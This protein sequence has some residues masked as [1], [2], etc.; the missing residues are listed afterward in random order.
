MSNINTKFLEG[1][2]GIDPLK[3]PEGLWD[4]HT[5]EI[6]ENP[7]GVIP[8]TYHASYTP[9]ICDIPDPK[10]VISMSGQSSRFAAAGY[11]EPKFMIEVDGKKIIE[12]IVDLYPSD[13]DFLFI[14]NDDHAQDIDLVEFLEDLPIDQVSIVSVPVHKK[15]PV[16]CIDYIQDYIEDDTPVIFNYCDFS[17]D[18]DYQL[19]SDNN[20]LR[21][22]DAELNRCEGADGVIL[23]YTGFHPHMLINTKYAYCKVDKTFGSKILEVKEKESFTKYPMAEYASAGTYYFKKGSYVKKYFKELIEK[24]IN[25]DGE[26]YVSLVYNL[27]IRDGLMCRVWEC[28]RF[29][30]WGTPLDLDIYRRWSDYYRRVIHGQKEVTI[31]NC[32]TAMPMAGEGMRFREAGYGPPKPF[33]CINDQYMVDL[34][35]KCLPKTD[36]TILAPLSKYKTLF[37]VTDEVDTGST[38]WIDEVLPGQA[39]TTEKIVEKVEPEKSILVSACDNASFY[40]ADRFVELV[41]DKD[42]DIIVWSYRNNYTTFNNA[43]AYSWLDVN[44]EDII[45]NVSVKKFTGDNPLDKHA[46]T[47]TMF[48]RNKDIYLNSLSKLY[49]NNTRT[50]D[51]FYIDNLLNEAI[52]LGYIVRNFEIESYICW[53]TPGD[54]ET[55]RYWQEFFNKV[56]WHPYDYEK[57]YF[58]N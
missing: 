32:V 3:N 30:Q 43:N 33:L 40:D 7:P 13:S 14:I 52:K 55:Y 56:K 11:T 6:K 46:I 45:T 19:F 48:F 26:Y 24:D 10:I 44:D 22:E 23:C 16:Y 5:G 15:G 31:P 41:D 49:E 12:H 51:E 34:A 38:V 28:D 35:L 29:L 54:L 58:T 53:G 21:W 57:D 39:C 36:E 2:G 8:H 4:L 47:G 50:N 20:K 17:M 37:G 42:N 27:M 9:V 1:T 18:W 25:I